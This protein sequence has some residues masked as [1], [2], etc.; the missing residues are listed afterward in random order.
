MMLQLNPQIPLE[1]PKGKGRAFL[2]I[3]P[4]DEDDLIFAT[5]IDESCEIWCFRT[6]DIRAQQNITFGRVKNS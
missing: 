3:D 6:R 2:V 5:I 4:G 1:T